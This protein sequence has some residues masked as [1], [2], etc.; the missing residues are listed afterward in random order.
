M[1]VRMAPVV[2]FG[3]FAAGVG[4]TLSQV[5]DLV[6][7]AQLTWGERR[8]VGIVALITLG[9]FALAGWVLSRLL[10]AVAELAEVFIDQAES[11]RRAA[12]LVEW[13][14]VPALGRIAVALERAAAAAPRDDGRALALAGAQQ[15]IEDEKFDLAE[16]LVAAFVRDY[17]AAPEGGPLADELAAAREEAITDLRVRL[18]AARSAND[19]EQAIEYRDQLTQHLRGDALRALDRDLVKWLMSLIQKRMRHGTVRSDVASLAARV[20]DSFG[21]TPEGA[22]LRASLPTL[23]RSAGLCPRCATPYNGLG[24]ACPKC[25]KSALAPRAGVPASGPRIAPEA[26]P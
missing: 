23:R 7:D 10:K 21:D 25:L 4:L 17:P 13:N 15:A 5:S 3:L 22:S 14:V 6:S 12:E 20:A 2:R 18:D 8:V 24:E 16:R 1:L 19:P 11:A 26:A 9:S